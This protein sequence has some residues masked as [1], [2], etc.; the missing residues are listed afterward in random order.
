MRGHER[1]PGL[2]GSSALMGNRAGLT[3]ALPELH[4]PWAVLLTESSPLRPC[5]AR[6]RARVRSEHPRL[7][8]YALIYEHYSK[9]LLYSER[10]KQV[11]VS[12][13]LLPDGTM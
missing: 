1:L 6:A 4:L 9:E 7:F 13:D 11:V 10:A 2:D 3:E 12:P 5:A 8:E